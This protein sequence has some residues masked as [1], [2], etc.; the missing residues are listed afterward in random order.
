MKYKFDKELNSAQRSVEHGKII[1]SKK[2]LYKIYISWYNVILKELKSINEDVSQLKIVELGSGGGFIKEIIPNVITSD[3]LEIGNLDMI[4][5]ALEMPFEDDQLDAIVMVDTFHHI[6]NVEKF[7]A[8]AQR[9]LKNGRKIIMIEP[10]KT[11]WGSFIYKN[12][13]HEDFD[14][15][16]K[17]WQ[18]QSDGPL[19]SANGALPWIVFKR[20]FEIFSQKFTQLKLEKYKNH[21]PIIYLLSGG[22]SM[23]QLMPNFSF[24][25]FKTLDKI[26][27][28]I[29]GFGMFTSIVVSVK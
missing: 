25:F 14:T 12:F 11:W 7:L 3:I 20:D 2:F 13:H 1:R 17:Q 8:E 26:L 23:P 28:L 9:C 19:S 21:S 15:K 18:F 24:G 10:A 22:L 16:V 4:F 29:S 6:P 27:S 5:S